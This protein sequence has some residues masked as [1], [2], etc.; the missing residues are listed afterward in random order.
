MGISEIILNSALT[1]DPGSSGLIWYMSNWVSE[2][3][4]NKPVT[5][6]R[7]FVRLHLPSVHGLR[8]QVL[9]MRCSPCALANSFARLAR[10]HH[11]GKFP[12]ESHGAV[13][14]RIAR[15]FLSHSQFFFAVISLLTPPLILARRQ[16]G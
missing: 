13:S 2:P 10:L 15:F 14:F 3:A 7:A 11:C 1:L 16:R 5:V 6:I 12:L 4:L 9:A 8:R